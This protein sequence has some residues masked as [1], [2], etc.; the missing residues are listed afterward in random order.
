MAPRIPAAGDMD[1]DLSKD[2]LSIVVSAL[3]MFK[4]QLGRVGSGQPIPGLPTAEA[5]K[6]VDEIAETR[7]GSRRLL[8]WAPALPTALIEALSHGWDG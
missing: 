4:G 1:R 6:K 8:L 2:E 3:W 7:W 5:R